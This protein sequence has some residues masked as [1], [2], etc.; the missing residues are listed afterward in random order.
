MN[1]AFYEINKVS[2]FFSPKKIVLGKNI[3]KKWGRR[4]NIRWKQSNYCH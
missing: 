1:K 2:N 4:Q 3:V